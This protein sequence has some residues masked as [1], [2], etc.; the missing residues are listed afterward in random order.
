MMKPKARVVNGFY[1]LDPLPDNAGPL[2][3]AIHIAAQQ[4]LDAIHA[5][6]ITR[7][8]SG[9]VMEIR[10]ITGAVRMRFGPL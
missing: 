3:T 2:Q 9:M 5:K 6:C 7:F 4:E 10:S 8:P 1:V